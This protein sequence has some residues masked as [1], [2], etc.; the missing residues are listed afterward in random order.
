MR[1]V[2][3]CVMENE[4]QASSLVTR[5][6]WRAG[7]AAGVTSGPRRTSRLK[8]FPKLPLRLPAQPSTQGRDA[9]TLVAC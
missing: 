3:A 5:P 7:K 4:P 9:R 2:G 6:W 1:L 8:Q